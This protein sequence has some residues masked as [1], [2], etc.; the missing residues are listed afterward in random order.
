MKKEMVLKI[1]NILKT[2]C[3]ND[4]IPSRVWK[5]I[6]RKLEEKEISSLTESENFLLFDA[7]GCND[8][9]EDLSEFDFLHRQSTKRFSSEGGYY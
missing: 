7:I 3:E 5:R 9:D 6:L 2:H 4:D 8:A 1:K